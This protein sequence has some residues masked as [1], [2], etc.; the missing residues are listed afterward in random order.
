MKKINREELSVLEK[1]LSSQEQDN[2]YKE[3]IKVLDAEKV[4]KVDMVNRPPH[5]NEHP[6]QIEC[7]EMTRCM[8][9]DLANAFKYVFRA[10]KKGDIIEDLKK[11]LWYLNDELDRGGSIIVR[12]VDEESRIKFKENLN[13]IT[14]HSIQGIN[15]ILHYIGKANYTIGE[16]KTKNIKNAII[17][18]ETFIDNLTAMNKAQ[19][20]NPQS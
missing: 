9:P 14:F 2:F 1:P 7:I 20:E 11:A 4:V 15:D 19:Y 18:L 10:G 8:Y 6:S 12:F 3:G 16:V 17:E 5:Y 13:S